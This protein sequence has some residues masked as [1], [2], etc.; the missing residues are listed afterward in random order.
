MKRNRTPTRPY[1]ALLRRYPDTPLADIPWNELPTSLQAMCWQ[2][3]HDWR[4]EEGM[5]LDMTLSELL[6][7]QKEIRRAGTHRRYRLI[8]YIRVDPEDEEPMTYEEALREKEQQEFLFP[9]NLYRIE[10]IESPVPADRK[11]E[12]LCI[13]PASRK[14]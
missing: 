11:E 4:N 8:A 7:Y 1:Q 14:S 12:D 3:I 5:D 6:A 9:E 13:P 10:E 2:I